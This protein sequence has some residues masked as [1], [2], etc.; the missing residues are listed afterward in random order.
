M[1][2]LILVV[3]L[4]AAI[5][6]L[7]LV[8]RGGKVLGTI[9]VPRQGRH[10][11]VYTYDGEPLAGVG[12]GKPFELVV[13]PGISTMSSVYTG[14]VWSDSACLSYNGCKIGFPAS[15]YYKRV[16]SNLADR[17]R[18]VRV[19]ATITSY[20]KGGWPNIRLDMPQNNWFKSVM[21]GGRH[22]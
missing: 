22:K 19:W 7:V 20:D 1:I 8:H 18:Q 2:A 6:Y 15:G 10:G 21:N 9:Y 3:I 14:T 11:K 5:A 13:V 17:H 16:L 12:V 4:A